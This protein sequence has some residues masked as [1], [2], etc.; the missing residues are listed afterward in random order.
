[1]RLNEHTA[2]VQLSFGVQLTPSYRR[3]SV[4]GSAEKL[5]GPLLP[6]LRRLLSRPFLGRLG[7]GL[8]RFVD[9]ANDGLATGPHVVVHCW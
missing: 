3:D 9:S 8:L 5:P 4:S 2:G 1:M 7:T 6:E